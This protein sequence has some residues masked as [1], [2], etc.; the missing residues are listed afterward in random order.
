MAESLTA[1]E[2]ERSQVQMKMSQLGDMRAG[3]ITTTG[4]RCGNPDAQDRRQ[5]RYR[6]FLHTGRVT[7]GSGRSGGV[8]PVQRTEPESAR[9]E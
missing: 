6:D 3:S 8:S 7:K 4:G 1:L 5:D 2:M 9:C